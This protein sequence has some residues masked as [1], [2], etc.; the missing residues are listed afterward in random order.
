ME[1]FFS[2]CLGFAAGLFAT[3]LMTLFEIPFWKK[4]GLEGILEWHE[5]QILFSKLLKKDVEILNFRGIFL[6][7]FLNGGLGGTGLYIF[8]GIFPILI[9]YAYILGLGYAIFLWVLTLLPIHQPITG[10]NPFRHP[11]GVGPLFASLAGHVIYGI[12][13]SLILANYS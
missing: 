7:H 4:W 9:Q 11:Q 1:Y 2:A 3:F 8:V 6:L 10:I 13:L 12:S 5:N